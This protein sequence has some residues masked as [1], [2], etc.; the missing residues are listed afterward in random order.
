MNKGKERKGRVESPKFTSPHSQRRMSRYI[1][2][3]TT[4]TPTNTRAANE[5]NVIAH[6]TPLSSRSLAPLRVSRYPL[7]TIR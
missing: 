4:P 3:T 2:S 6:P 7:A 5:M 1:T